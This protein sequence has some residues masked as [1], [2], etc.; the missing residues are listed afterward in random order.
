[1]TNVTELVYIGLLIVLIGR[2][3][4]DNFFSDHARKEIIALREEV[5]RLAEMLN[6]D[7]FVRRLGK[8]KRRGQKPLRKTTKKVTGLSDSTET[9]ILPS[10]TRTDTH[11]RI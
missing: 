7:R 2:I 1:M 11:F 8:K 10:S 9:S 6:E 5:R 4:K 3:A